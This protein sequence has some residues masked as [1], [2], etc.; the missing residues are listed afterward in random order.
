MARAP[1][2]VPPHRS[3]TQLLWKFARIGE[4]NLPYTQVEMPANRLELDPDRP[5]TPKAQMRRGTRRAPTIPVDAVK[6]D[7][8]TRRIGHLVHRA[9]GP[10]HPR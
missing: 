9:G 1:H 6:A 3:V 2:P 10:S 8:A 7:V 5:L 4:V